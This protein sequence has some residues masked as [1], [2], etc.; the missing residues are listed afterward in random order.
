M[1]RENPN[2]PSVAKAL[3][4]FGATDQKLLVLLNRVRDS[5]GLPPFPDIE[6]ATE[7]SKAAMRNRKDITPAELDALLE[8]HSD[9][10][11]CVTEPTDGKSDPLACP[12]CGGIAD[13]G[14]DVDG[15]PHHCLLCQEYLESKLPDPDLVGGGQGRKGYNPDPSGFNPTGWI[16]G[17]LIAWGAAWCVAKVIGVFVEGGAA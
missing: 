5:Q 10:Q 3:E 15:G 11:D 8:D 12:S 7:Y 17:G 2:N 13:D 1:E 4:S 9:A 6:A 14:L 16:I